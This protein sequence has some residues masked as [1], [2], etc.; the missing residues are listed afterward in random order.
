MEHV[1]DHNTLMDA[2]GQAAP[3]DSPSGSAGEASAPAPS[4]AAF[5]PLFFAALIAAAALAGLCGWLLSQRQGSLEREGALS[6]RLAQL[7]TQLAQ[8]QELVQ[9]RDAELEQRD[10]ALAQ[11]QEAIDTLAE[12]SVAAPD[13]TVPEYTQLYPDFYAQPWEGERVEGGRVC[14]L[15]F[16]DGPSRNT[17]RVLEILDRYGVKATFFVV[18]STA[19]SAASQQRMQDIVAAGHTL[20]MHS[21]SH[22]YKKIYASVEAFLDDF[23][24]L[25]QYIHEVTGVYPQVFRFPGGSING[26]DRGVYQEIIAEMTRRGFV[27][28]DWNASAQDATVRP[29]PAAD[30]AAD[31]LR[32]VGRDLAVVLCHDSAARG[33]T[34]DA[35]PA[36]IEGYQRAGYTFSALHP[37]V[38]QVTMGY[39]RIR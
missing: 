6:R 26:Y 27:Y 36:V 32:G 37:G 25:Y 4:H 18:G 3:L 8:Q 11:A 14:C 13:G 10:D 38:E 20:A 1:V 39:P 5:K 19:A 21:W 7:E 35:L 16:D 12:Y 31:C 22:D 23:Y 24:R 28:F 34:V 29:R 2:E 33:T 15:T 17:G 9:E 30:I